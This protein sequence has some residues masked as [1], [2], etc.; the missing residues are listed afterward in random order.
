M[1]QLSTIVLS[2]ILTACGSSGGGSS[3]PDNT[4]ESPTFPE[5]A[6]TYSHTTSDFTITC[7]DGT[8]TTASPIAI[9]VNVY[10][11]GNALELINV[12]L[13][14]DNAPTPGIT[15]YENT[16]MIGLIDDEGR[17]ILNQIVDAYM[18]GLGD[19]TISYTT[20]VN[21]GGSGWYGD[22][23]YTV[24]TDDLNIAQQQLYAELGLPVPYFSCTYKA[25]FDGYKLN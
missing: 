14:D 5:V 16:G 20:I 6:G 23:E 12:T 15:I 1:K 9:N 24:T 10:Q 18:T 19:V 17:A 2:L 11:D 3:T 4:N 8:S 13:E 21:F 7:A 25:T 22:F